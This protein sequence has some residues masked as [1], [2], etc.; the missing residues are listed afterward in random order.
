M[1]KII[2]ELNYIP[3]N[4]ARNLKRVKSKSV[5][6]FVLGEYNPFFGEIVASLENEISIKGY[7]AVVHFHS[8]EKDSVKAAAQFII[9]KNLIG[10]LHL[11]GLVT[12]D[13]AF[14]LEGLKVP[15]V[16]ISGV[17]EAGVKQSLFSSVTINDD[18]AVHNIMNYL[19]DSGHRKIGLILSEKDG[20]CIT[21]ERYNSYKNFLANKGINFNSEYVEAGN[22]SLKSGYDAMEKLLNKDLGLTAIFSVNDLMAIGAIKA[23]SDSGLAVPRDISIVGFDGLEI[24]EYSSPSLTTVKQP[25]NEFGKIS[26]ELLFNQIDNSCETEHIILETEFVVRQSCKKLNY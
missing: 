21:L 25:S 3:N 9:E 16:I 5:G 7:S 10:L 6:I 13:K 8:N 19:Y 12:E 24:G 23:I 11:G 26:S 18:I 17:V 14:Y 4:S 20:R 2:K 1:Q 15:L 22:F